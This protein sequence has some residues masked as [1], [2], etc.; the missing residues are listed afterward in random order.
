MPTSVT[1]KQVAP[2]AAQAPP[3]EPD[4]QIPVRQT[5]VAHHPS[6]RAETE[7]GQVSGFGFNVNPKS[8]VPNLKSQVEDVASA[9]SPDEPAVPPLSLQPAIVV[10][11]SSHTEIP[12]VTTQA[13]DAIPVEPSGTRGGEARGVSQPIREMPVAPRDSFDARGIH[14]QSIEPQFVSSVFDGE[15]N[16]QPVTTSAPSGQQVVQPFHPPSAAF[17]RPSV[18]G[19][20]RVEG[21]MMMPQPKDEGGRMKDEST[22]SADLPPSSFLLHPSSFILTKPHESAAA[23]AGEMNAPPVIDQIVR[24]ARLRFGQGETEMSLRLNPPQLGR[25]HMRLVWT[26]SELT[27]HLNVETQAARQ[28][29]EANLPTLYQALSDQGIRVDHVA[30]SVGQN[31]TSSFA[32]A[33]PFGE[34]APSRSFPFNPYETARNGMPHAPRDAQQIAPS[35]QRPSPTGW[36]TVDYWA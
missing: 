32:N 26:G 9:A 34:G 27:A 3:V 29:V 20:E 35:V 7:E 14:P 8:Q 1:E 2:I 4:S 15:P 16:S 6:L 30:V 21:V 25:L 5:S 24:E 11:S 17:N 18:V 31:L 22:A 23:E 13:L 10:G 28:V 33:N 19:G 36:W 12:K